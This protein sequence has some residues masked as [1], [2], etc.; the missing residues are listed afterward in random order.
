MPQTANDSLI[1][2]IHVGKI[3]PL[4]PKAVPSGF[5]KHRVHS[6]VTVTHTGL[7]GDEQADLSVHGGPDKAVYGDPLAALD[8]EATG[9]DQIGMLAKC[10]SESRSRAAIPSVLQLQI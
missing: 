6:P 4:G 5:V 7:V 10:R 8:L 3:A 9:N 1:A 2:S